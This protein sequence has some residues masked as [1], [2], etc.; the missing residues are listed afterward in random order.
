M[1]MK[2]NGANQNKYDRSADS[3]VSNIECP[4]SL[5]LIS[6]NIYVREIDVNEIYN[7]ALPNAIDNISNCSASD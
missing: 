3:G 4:P 2:E 5:E 1:A 6:E 7:S